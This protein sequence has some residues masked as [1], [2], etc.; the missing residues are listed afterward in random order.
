[1]NRSQLQNNLA[2]TVTLI[3]GSML[4]ATLFLGYAVY[5]SSALMWPPLGIQKVS[6][7]LPLLSTIVIMA[8]SWF[9]YKSRSSL[10]KGL[11]TRAQRDVNWT[12][13]LGVVF[14]LTQCALWYHLKSTGIYLTT[15][16]IFGS[17]LY[18]FTWIHAF[19][20]VFGIVAILYLKVALK[21][22]GAQILQTTT[23]I[24]KF[25]H[26]LGVVWL[27]MFLTIFVI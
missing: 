14:M 2:M 9:M 24:E 18:G 12:L 22:N 7:F 17:V 13:L 8:S 25:W 26:F 16:G 6:I 4:F 11:G 1:M 5:R 3:M 19:H 23:N 27:I 10:E 21:K 20:M 15:S